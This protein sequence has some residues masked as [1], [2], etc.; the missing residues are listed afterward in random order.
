MTAIVRTSPRPGMVR[1]TRR[2]VRGWLQPSIT[3]KRKRMTTTVMTSGTSTRSPAVRWRRKRKDIGAGFYPRAPYNPA[4]SIRTASPSGRAPR[5]RRARWFVRSVPGSGRQARDACGRIRRPRKHHGDEHRR[6]RNRREGE[7]GDRPEEGGFHRRRGR[8]RAAHHELLSGGAGPLRPAR[9]GHCCAHARA[10]SCPGAGA[11]AREDAEEPHRHLRRQPPPVAVQPQPRPPERRDLRPRERQGQRR[12]NDR[13]VEPV[14]EGPEKVHER[15]PRPVGH[16]Q[17]ARGRERARSADDFRPAGRDPGDRRLHDRGPGCGPSAV[18][19]PV[20]RQRPD[21]HDRGADDD[22]QQA[23]RHRGPQDP[24]PRFRRPAAVSGSGAVE[25]RVRRVPRHHEPDHEPLR[26]RSDHEVPF[27]RP[28]GECVGGVDLHDRRVGSP[29]RFKRLGRTARH[30]SA[31]T[32]STS[33][34]TFRRC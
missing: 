3:L 17:A 19:L 24:H 32:C 11:G 15:R 13:R 10:G 21:L 30:P 33:E 26:V 20:A 28:G 2:W 34:T 8:P 5:C 27:R 14:A 16:P 23:R 12:G 25:V 9:R 31:S 4:M 1:P 18:L 29:D 22:D 6:R 7:P